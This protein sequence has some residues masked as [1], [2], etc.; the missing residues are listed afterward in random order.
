MKVR[1]YVISTDVSRLDMDAIFRFLHNDA[2]WSHG[3]PRHVLERSIR[4]SLCFGLYAGNSLAGFARVVS[5]YA[6]FAYL[7][8]VFVLPEHRGKGLSK[9]LLKAIMS[10]PDLKGLRRFQLVTRDAQRLYSQFGFKEISDPR[11]YMEKITPARDLYQERP[12]D[13]TPS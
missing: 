2:Y 10:H 5:D 7:G 12:R 11:R 9:E 4:H 6:T 1:D 13:S 8:D 3:I